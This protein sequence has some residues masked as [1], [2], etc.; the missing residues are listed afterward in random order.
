M[1]RIMR[2][3]ES[4]KQG[5]VDICKYVETDIK[6]EKM[7]EVGSYI[8]QSTLIFYKNLNNLKELISVDPFSLNF[9]SDNLFNT[10]N[11]DDIYNIFLNN[12]KPYENIKHIKLCSEE[13]SKNFS[14]EY[15]DFIYIDGCHKYESVINDV[16]C[17]KR[18]IKK[19][20]F[21]AFH[22]VDDINVVRALSSFFDI[23]SGFIT[24]DNSI[25]FK[26]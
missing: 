7:C 4:G 22:D 11:I 18:K 5:L 21:M 9:N 17:W 1:I 8:G 19:G 25:T 10:T 12:I 23:N 13:A 26:I 2:P 15:F 6:V 20:G 3:D 24:S 16:N 14:D